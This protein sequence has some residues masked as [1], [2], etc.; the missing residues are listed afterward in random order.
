MSNFI[1][2]NFYMFFVVLSSGCTTIGS[3]VLSNPDVYLSEAEFIKAAP[4]E[5]GFTRSEFCSP[6]KK[7]CIPY[8]TAPPY[9]ADDFPT[10]GSVYYN[11]HA[12]GNGVEN[13]VTHRMTADTFNRFKGTALLL[14]GYGGNKEVMMATAIYFRAI[15]MNVVIPDL[16][17]HGES[18]ETFVFAARE[19]QILSKLLGQLA[20]EIEGPTIVIGHSMGA[21]TASNLLSSEQVD[22]AI[23]LAPM[24]RFDLAA[25]KYLPYKAPFLSRI[26]SDHIDDI[27]IQ[28]M[29]NA[30]VTLDETDLLNNLTNTRKPVL[31]VN[32][33]IDSVSPPSYFLS[34]AN[35]QVTQLIF[36]NR[37]HSSLMAFDKQDSS[38]I[39]KWLLKLEDVQTAMYS[40][41]HE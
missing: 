32:S 40:S 39:E 41:S 34:D 19:H 4:E 27:I 7:E 11:L 31:L 1:K 28:T 37:A 15:G 30:S 3:Y 29:K 13:T 9:H 38:K 20:N 5:I 10:N 14:H 21:L 25:K 17:G 6:D 35:S 22:A 8:I 24:M 23:L 16:F 18:N 36:K 12:I 26:F 33:N 2:L